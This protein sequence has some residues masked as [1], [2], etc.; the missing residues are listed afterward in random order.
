MLQEIDRLRWA[1]IWIR[2]QWLDQFQVHTRF[3]R[4]CVLQEEWGRPRIGPF[5]QYQSMV[6]HTLRKRC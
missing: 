3:D 2:G 1:L 4:S 6:G 5:A